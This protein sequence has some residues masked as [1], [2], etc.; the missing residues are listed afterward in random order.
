MIEAVQG[1]INRCIC[2]QCE[3]KWDSL[4]TPTNCPGCGRRTWNGGKT[5]GRPRKPTTAQISKP[6]R[7]RNTAKRRRELPEYADEKW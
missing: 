3:H 5:R 6:A 7:R 1:T 2:D 4:T